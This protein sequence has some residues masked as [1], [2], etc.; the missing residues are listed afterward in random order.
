[1]VD[2]QSCRACRGGLGRDG[3]GERDFPLRRL[4]QQE[5]MPVVL[6]APEARV[7]RRMFRVARA[8]LVVAGAPGG[9]RS[10]TRPGAERLVRKSNPL[11]I[12]T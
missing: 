9:T 11:R 10:P 5:E 12:D 8:Q 3:C 6:H 2:N 7:H 1:M 4:F